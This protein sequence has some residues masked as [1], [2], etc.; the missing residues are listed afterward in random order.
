[1]ART[2][3]IK[4]ERMH[5]RLDAPSKRKLERAAAYARKSVSEFVLDQ[6]LAAAQRTIDEREKIVLSAVDWDAFYEALARP[7]RPKA[8]LRSG[9]RW[10]RKLTA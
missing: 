1:M 7:P 4:Q 8:E 10:Y 9:F 3:G 2:A 5:L 6:A